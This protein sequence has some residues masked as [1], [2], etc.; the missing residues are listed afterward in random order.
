MM[1][2]PEERIHL[3]TGGDENFA[4]GL[5]VTVASALLAIPSGRAVTVHILD[6]GLAAATA[7][8][9]EALAGRIHPGCQLERH[10]VSTEKFAGFRPGIGN[11]RMYYAR[12]GIGS[13]V[14][15]GRA[16]YLDADVVVIGPLDRLWD[17]DLGDKMILA[18][19]DRK[20][21][22]LRD[23]CPWPLTE[24]AG[25]LPYFNTGVLL[26][27]LDR[28][29]EE[30]TEARAME[31]AGE[32]G[33]ACRWYDQTVLNFLLRER[34]G[35]LPEKWNWQRESLPDDGPACVVH[36]TTG[37]KPWL[38]F[39]PDARFRI[40]RAFYQFAASSTWPLLLHRGAAA[41]LGFGLLENLLR[42]VPALRAAYVRLLKRMMKNSA[43]AEKRAQIAG[44]IAYFT[45][46][47]G[48]PMGGKEVRR[49]H[50]ALD[51]VRSRLRR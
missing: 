8:R 25:Q 49:R 13:F 14:S 11:S 2:D 16:L 34:I 19:K 30:G 9:L 20:I 4:S 22:H 29:R 47:P 41:G 5:L 37:K 36:F 50:P 31:L 12:L 45:A 42:K 27:D 6:G 33:M 18:V 44:T 21:A 35:P 48:G 39:G 10:A 51:A 23:D 46:G 43:S 17:L 7:A 38:H 26:I 1:P 24:A 28:W 40:W 15:A 3:V 32:A